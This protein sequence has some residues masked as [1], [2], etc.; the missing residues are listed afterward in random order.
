HVTGTKTRQVGDTG[1]VMGT[2]I[3]GGGW[4]CCLAGG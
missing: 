3:R 1:P 2:V 4:I